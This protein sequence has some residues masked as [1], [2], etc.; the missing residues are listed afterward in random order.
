MNRD[1]LRG[2]SIYSVFIR[3]H[4]KTGDI[5]GLIKDLHRIK[6][7]GI[8]IIWILPHYPIGEKNRKGEK[9]SPYAIS[10]YLSVNSDLGG[11]HDFKELVNSCHELGLKII[12]DIVFNHTSCDS[13]LA[14]EHPDWFIKNSDNKIIGKISGWDDVY[15]LD[16]TNND[17]RNYLI[18]VLH[19]WADLNIDGFRCD[20]A[21]VVPLSFWKMAKDTLSSDH[22]NLIW[23]GESVDKEFISFIRHKGYQC[24]S[25]SELYNVFDILYDY[26]VQSTLEGYISGDNTFQLFVK[27]RRNQEVVYP[28]DYLKL[29]FLENHDT[30]NRAAELIKDRYHLINWKAFSMFE[31]GIPLIYAGEEFRIN[32]KP[33]L[34]SDDKIDWTNIDEKYSNFIRKLLRIEH[35]HIVICGI[36][37]INPLADDCVHLRYRYNG[38][39]LHGI[40]N[41]GKK[42]R[43][44]EVEVLKGEYLNVVTGNNFDIE[45]EQL[46]LDHAP[47]IFK[48]IP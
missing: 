22:K 27:E 2:E 30:D 1:Q 14:M 33:D 19:Y 10:D 21:A 18:Q 39:T 29:R 35:M 28:V 20:V 25:D 7:L 48:S 9:G 13:E 47:F 38:E 11:L 15:D 4:S 40:F 45:N 32:N 34:F 26:D 12:I 41:F 8:T 23:I 3:N 24:H 46:E 44:I 16:F 43:T 42:N 6:D 17:M 37:T 36:Y 5:Q 31:K